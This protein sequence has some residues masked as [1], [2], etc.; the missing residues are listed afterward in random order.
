MRQELSDPPALATLASKSHFSSAVRVG[1]TV[2][3]SGTVGCTPEGKPVEGM[4]AQ[5]RLAFE[6]LRSAL[7]AAGA[8]LS[9]VVELTTFHTD[10]QGDMRAFYKAKDEFF[11]SSFPAWTAVGVTQLSF[12]GLLVEIRAV[13]VAGSGASTQE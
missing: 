10:L 4:A 7:T 13:A 11:P 6:N 9:D 5:A 1:D 12:P 3:L 8:S 2:W